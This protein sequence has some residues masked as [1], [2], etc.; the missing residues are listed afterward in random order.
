MH[1]TTPISATLFIP[2]IEPN[3]ANRDLTVYTVTLQYKTYIA[4]VPIYWIPQDTSATV[5]PPPSSCY[6]SHANLDTGYYNCYNYTYF[7]YLIY[8]ALVSA[9]TTLKALATAGGDTG[10]DGSLYAPILTWDST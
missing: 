4:E 10:I 1:T 5:P 7:C 9:H 8:E 3:Q 6:N 2:S